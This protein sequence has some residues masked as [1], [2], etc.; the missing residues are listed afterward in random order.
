MDA[1]LGLAGLAGPRA[2]LCSGHSAKGTEGWCSRGLIDAKALEGSTRTNTGRAGGGSE[3]QLQL[4]EG[5]Q[6]CSKCYDLARNQT[7]LAGHSVWKP[8]YG[9][10]G[11]AGG[12]RAWPG[13]AA[14][15]DRG[16]GS[17]RVLTCPDA[18]WRNAT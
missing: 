3:C 8:P 16:D 11:G 12:T 13:R 9:S 6:M 10:A 2:G 18:T 5:D 7:A 17:D 15:T 1:G 4:V 14:E